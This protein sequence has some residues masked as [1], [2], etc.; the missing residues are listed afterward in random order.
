MRERDASVPC[1]RTR[2]FGGSSVALL[3]LIPL[4]Q[5]T[6]NSHS[7]IMFRGYSWVKSNQLPPRETDRVPERDNRAGHSSLFYSSL[8]THDEVLQVKNGIAFVYSTLAGSRKMALPD[9]IRGGESHP[10]GC[11]EREEIQ[12]WMSSTR[13]SLNSI[14]TSSWAGYKGKVR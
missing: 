8:K 7:Q 10:P 9:S 11:L 14:S 12:V 4:A 1:V 6:T 2:W 13:I 5:T 3:M